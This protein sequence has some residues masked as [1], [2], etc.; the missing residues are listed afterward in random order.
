M[1]IAIIGAGISGLT[2]AYLLNRKH[3]ITV[4][5]SDSRI[6]GHT[7]TID[8]SHKGKDY[9]I[10][11]GFIVFNDWT[12]PNFK[13]LLKQLKVDYQITDM[14][15]SV[16]CEK[17]GLEYSGN[18]LNTLF[19][20]RKNIFKLSHWQMIKDI[21]RF[22]KEALIDIESGG[23]YQEMTLGQ[24]LV[25][26]NYSN[27]FV[28]KYLIPMGAAIWSAS[29]RVMQDFPLQ[30]FVRFF[31]N[32]GL[33]SVNDRP[34]WH[35]VKGGSRSY[36]QPLTQ[37]F[38]KNIR[39]NSQVIN[40]ARINGKV[41]VSTA[42]DT[43]QYD[44]VVL[45][46][47]SDQ[48]LAMLSDASQTEF[49]V[50]SAI[51]YQQNDV[52]LHTDSSLLPK[53]QLTWS[54]WNYRIVDEPETVNEAPPVLTYDMNILQSIRSEDTFCVTLNKTD[55]IDPSKIIGKYNYAHPVFSTEAIKAQGRW[56]EINGVNNTWFCGAY[57]ANGFHEDGVVSGLKVANKFG[58]EL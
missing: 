13:Q 51:R 21:L 34:Q 11:T 49:D 15:F 47:H 37:L 56:D 36:L 7:A 26:K 44:Q 55:A 53:S 2:A 19:A 25:E 35:V 41:E 16:C 46:C 18:N 30:F 14:G 42:M 39:V 10:D 38:E 58:E 28:N 32:H 29:T 20:Q 5:E 9:S 57:W 27:T 8:V 45:A 23:I 24:Y 50:L 33:L 22:N 31:K 43:E 40:I 17:T 52:V 4:Y 54:S 3:D 12:Y 48:A 1:K 6:G